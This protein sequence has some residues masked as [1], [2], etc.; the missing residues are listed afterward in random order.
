MGIFTKKKTYAF[1]D[2]IRGLQQAVSGAHEMMQAQQVQS[3][4]KFW[5][6]ND[7]KPVCKKVKIGGEEIDVPLISLVSHSHLE[8]EDVEIK[9]RVRIGDAEIQT[10]ANPTQENSRLS[11]AELQLI[12]ENIK[13]TDDDVMD[14][15]VHFKLKNG[16][17]GVTSLVNCYNKHI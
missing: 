4:Q 10:F 5:Q 11:Y 16:S 12:A 7:G 17:E 2:I 15:T 1:S 9:F 13:V 6:T 8:M 14:I 3:L